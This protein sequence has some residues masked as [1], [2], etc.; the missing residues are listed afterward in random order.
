MGLAMN[1]NSSAH[2]FLANPKILKDIMSRQAITR[3]LSEA[4]VVDGRGNTLARAGFGYSLGFNFSSD[5]FLKGV[6]S[7]R[8]GDVVIFSGASDDRIIAGITLE[9]FNNA[10]Q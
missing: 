4:I 9:A 6:L 7:S 10:Y 2:K 8:P 1:I 3:E 5:D